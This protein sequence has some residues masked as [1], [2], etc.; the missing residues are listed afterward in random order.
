PGGEL[1]PASLLKLSP[2]S[3]F[4]LPPN[5]VMPSVDLLSPFP[6]SDSLPP[7]PLPPLDSK[8]IEDPLP[9]PSLSLPP[10]PPHPTQ[11]TDT[12]L[13][14]DATLPVVNS[15]TGLSTSVPVGGMDHSS[16]EP[17]AKNVLSSNLAQ[18]DVKQ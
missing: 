16:T 4:S 12:L 5:K 15:P 2:P 13:P 14:Q 6:L 11:E 1:L 17:P 10:P 7:E 9:P 18:D 3:S 8:A